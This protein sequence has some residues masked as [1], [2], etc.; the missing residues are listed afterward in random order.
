MPTENSLT[1]PPTTTR[2]GHAA[3]AIADVRLT[4]DQA[5]GALPD[6]CM[7]CG[8]PATVWIN[9]TF[10]LHEPVVHGRSVLAEIYIVQFLF[11]AAKTAR[12]NLR[13][14]FCPRHRHYWALRFALIFGGLGGM[15]V[16][17]FGGLSVVV[18][19]FAVVK[20]DS[21]WPTGCVLVPLIAYLVAWIITMKL[22]MDRSIRAR[23]TEDG[24]I[25]LQNVGV[26]YIEAIK[27]GRR[28]GR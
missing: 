16:V 7:C 25:A 17:L 3:T 12:L 11:A 10:M 14:S 23:L 5:E 22:V 18:F 13:T 2:D 21:P 6:V 26:H 27:A 19:L 8:A 28:L 20:V 15:F 4:R 9:R 24:E 1:L